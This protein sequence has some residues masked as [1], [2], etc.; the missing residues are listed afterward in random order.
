VGLH[1]GECERRGETLAGTAVEVGAGVLQAT[2]A[3]EILAT[4]AVRELVAGSGLE[5]RSVGAH[6]LD[7]LAGKWELYA[8]ED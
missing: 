5:L 3:G 2:Q 8:L 6:A 7:G 4:A 1:I